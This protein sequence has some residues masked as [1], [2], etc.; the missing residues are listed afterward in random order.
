MATVEPSTSQLW[1]H[2]QKIRKSIQRRL[3]KINTENASEAEDS[4]FE[5]IDGIL[6]KLR[7]A[8]ATTIF[9]DFKFAN[10]EGVEEVLWDTHIA[11]NAEYRRVLKRP[12]NPAQAVE[13]R[14]VE[15]MYH[16]FLRIAQ[17]FYIGYIQRLAARFDIPELRRAAQG[18]NAAPM[19][20]GD[21]ISQLTDDMSHLVLQSCHSTLLHLGDLARYRIQAKRGSS[22]YDMALTYYNLA[23]HIMPRSG[24]ALHQIGIVNLDCGNHLDVV[25]NFYRSRVSEVPHPNAKANLENEFKTLRKPKH[26]KG[27]RSP[28]TPQ[29]V[30]SSWFV[31]LHAFFYQGERFPQHEELEHEVMHRLDM[32]CRDAAN[33]G[34]LLK[35]ALVNICAHDVACANYAE[36]KT[37]A[38]LRFSQFSL[39]FNAQFLSRV[40]RALE[41]TL[42]EAISDRDHSASDCGHVEIVSVVET[43]LPILRIYCVWIASQRRELFGPGVAT[44]PAIQAM[45][46][47]LAQVFTQLCV[48]SYTRKDLA[49]APYLLP[50]DLEIRGVPSL[51]GDSVPADCRVYSVDGVT[52]K[53]YIQD[54]EQ[55][56]DGLH[57]NLARILDVLRC[58]YFMAEDT[59]TPLSCNVVQDSLVFEYQ[60]SATTAPA[61]RNIGQPSPGSGAQ[62]SGASAQQLP[63]PPTWTDQMI[64]RNTPSPPV[65]SAIEAQTERTVMAMLSPFLGP[66]T[67]QKDDRGQNR[68]SSSSYGMHTDTANDVFGSAPTPSRPNSFDGPGALA[69]YPWA[70]DDMPKPVPAVAEAY[71]RASGEIQSVGT[72][73]PRS[74]ADNAFANRSPGGYAAPTAPPSLFASEVPRQAN[75]GGSFASPADAAH[76]ERLL[77]SLSGHA[78]AQAAGHAVRSPQPP[79]R[80]TELPSANAPP[81][82]SMAS[83]FSHPS[84]LYQGTPANGNVRDQFQGPSP[85]RAGGASRGARGQTGEP[86]SRFDEGGRRAPWGK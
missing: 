8:C 61:D 51:T 11:I 76:R 19:D 3:E 13:R 29:D 32:A 34:T 78:P 63:A 26:D 47:I 30:F 70:W 14:K 69:P 55:R 22:G 21:R 57:E 58:A 31:K 12:K 65:G 52:H 50:E 15:K 60:S 74:P 84:S 35:M 68:S 59:A 86:T 27:R 56:L 5:A 67:P 44:G 24:F 66:P 2:A 54:P 20:S 46:Q 36:N 73:P 49:S 6:E 64:E 62:A 18:V 48:V 39:R 1:G 83:Y 42:R 40:C 10:T 16:N 85:Y 23:R 37:E 33:S 9:L 25:Y 28:S 4:K 82:S 38:A 71:K 17:K 7:L 53:S 43:L 81:S 41:T 45:M 72:M 80:W 79:P 75:V 77:Q